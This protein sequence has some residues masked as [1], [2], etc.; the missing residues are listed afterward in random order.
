MDAQSSLAFKQALQF[1]TL[2][3]KHF[4]LLL[5][6]FKVKLLPQHYERVFF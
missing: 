4:K 3:M 6:C 5:S 2:G 1:S